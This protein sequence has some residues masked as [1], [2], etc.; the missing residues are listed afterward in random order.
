MTTQQPILNDDAFPVLLV[1]GNDRIATLL[2][3]NALLDKL[4]RNLE[5]WIVYINTMS[6]NNWPTDFKCASHCRSCRDCVDFVVNR[7]FG[8][9]LALVYQGVY[10]EAL[11]NLACQIERRLQTKRPVWL[12][13]QETMPL[14]QGRAWMGLGPPVTMVDKIPYVNA[15]GH[16]TVR[17]YM[18]IHTMATQELLPPLNGKDRFILTQKRLKCLKT[19]ISWKWVEIFEEDWESSTSSNSDGDDDAVSNESDEEDYYDVSEEIRIARIS[20][21]WPGATKSI[22][23]HH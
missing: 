6:I 22:W 21:T 17:Y 23:K 1:G 11:Q 14:F 16:D 15:N 20:S 18:N 10:C 13:T 19:A 7:L 9:K 12:Y 8:V 4:A 3:D 2:G 5:Y